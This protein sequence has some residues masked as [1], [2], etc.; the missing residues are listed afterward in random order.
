MRFLGFLIASAVLTGGTVVLYLFPPV[1]ASIYPPCP[2]FYITG[3]YCPGCGSTRC[4]HALVHGNLY[5]AAAYNIL[6]LTA[7]PFLLYRGAIFLW[8]VGREKPPA[9]RRLPAWAIYVLFG[10]LVVFWIA[11]N[12]PYPPFNWLAPHALS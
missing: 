12:I 3:L 1:P 7:I 11:R 8:Y 10:V 6:L 2:F 4:L 5:Q 9:G